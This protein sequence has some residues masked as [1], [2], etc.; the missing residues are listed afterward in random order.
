METVV[1][2]SGAP[3]A[4]SAKQDTAITHLSNIA[5]RTPALATAA[6]GATQALSTTAAAGLSVAA[7]RRVWVTFD[8]GQTGVCYVGK[9]NKVTNAGANAIDALYPGDRVP[10]EVDNASRLYFV[11]SAGTPSIRLRGE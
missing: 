5:T 10:F 9:D 11:A 4:T 3:L 8:L 7:T 6:T 2:E 1:G